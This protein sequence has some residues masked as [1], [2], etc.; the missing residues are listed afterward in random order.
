MHLRLE[1]TWWKE[2]TAA[3]LSV[4]PQKGLWVPTAENSYFCPP[5]NP[6]T[7]LPLRER[8]VATRQG[9]ITGD[10]QEVVSVKKKNVRRAGGTDGEK[11]GGVLLGAWDCT[12]HKELMM[13]AMVWLWNA[14]G[15]IN[16]ATTRCSPCTPESLAGRQQTVK[17]Q[18]W[19]SG[20]RH[21]LCK[22]LRPRM[23]RMFKKLANDFKT[24]VYCT[25][26][27]ENLTCFQPPHCSSS[28]SSVEMS[29]L[30]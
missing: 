23:L 27:S 26:F 16:T 25:Y 19:T 20:N 5:R 7:C 10:K 14:P 8:T 2:M 13:M 30:C 11:R 22:V 21:R 29:R 4:S 12:R 18:D 6:A 1:H 15:R 28:F 3:H 24:Q 17:P 9:S